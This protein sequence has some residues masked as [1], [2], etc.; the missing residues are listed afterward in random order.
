M[1][2]HK[3]LRRSRGGPEGKRESVRER[4]NEMSLGDGHKC[5]GENLGAGV[6]SIMWQERRAVKVQPHSE[7]PGRPLGADGRRK[8][9]ISRMGVPK[10]GTDLTFGLRIGRIT[11]TDWR[12]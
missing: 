4:E 11:D 1:V 6:V 9:R 2:T 8:G 7:I 3:A 12:R 10:G 5:G